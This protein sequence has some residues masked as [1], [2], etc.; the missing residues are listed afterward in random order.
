MNFA[1]PTGPL[2]P[3]EDF[4]FQVGIKRSPLHIFHAPSAEAPEILKQRRFWLEKDP[5]FFIASLPEADNNL[6]AGILHVGRL[7]AAL[8]SVTDNRNRLVL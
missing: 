5:Q 3:D 6:E 4:R 2:F 7:S 1:L 8:Y